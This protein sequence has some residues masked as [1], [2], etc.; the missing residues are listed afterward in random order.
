MPYR[1][2]PNTDQA[3]L[4]TLRKAIAEHGKQT[5]VNEL[6]IS[7]KVINDAK[8]Y[9]NNFEKTLSQ[10]QQALDS[11]V[12]ANKNY[13]HVVKNARLYIS[14]FIQVLNLSIIRNE[15]KREHKAFYKLE[16]DNFTVPD[17][18]TENALIEWGKNLI[19]GEAERLQNGGTPMFN[20]TIA[21]VKVHYDIFKEYKTNQRVYQQN[22]G[23]YLDIVANMRQ[24]GDVIIQDIWNEVE[25]KFDKLP[26]YERLKQCQNYGLI[27][28][29]RKGEKELTP[30]S[31]TNS[32]SVPVDSY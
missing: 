11:Q 14:H 24:T 22:T 9:L 27:Y 29:Y 12:S 23:R 20:P 19:D 10:Y 2:L 15:I 21:K 6:T 13:Q 32:Y 3:R 1:R 4:R 26:P 28:Y 31:D 25:A 16:P 18:S 17:L 5:N 8:V 30:A 7:Y